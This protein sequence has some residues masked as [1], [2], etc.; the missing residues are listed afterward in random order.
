MI[1]IYLVVGTANVLDLTIRRE[2][3]T[4]QYC[5]IN[6]YC[7][8][9]W[10]LTW[11][12]K[13]VVVWFYQWPHYFTILCIYVFLPG[14]CVVPSHSVSGL[15]Q[16]TCLGNVILV[17]VMQAEV[18]KYVCDRHAFAPLSLP[19]EQ[20]EANLLEDGLCMEQSWVTPVVQARDIPERC[21]KARQ[22]QKDP[23]WQTADSSY[24]NIPTQL[25]SP[26]QMRSSKS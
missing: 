2:L 17:S 19:W 26:E 18:W 7:D 15:H 1:L 14:N 22:H 3:F 6:R 25:R 4:N 12:N 24:M 5:E 21:G 16:V 10:Q 8:I 11:I 20:T 9:L 23:V 13:F